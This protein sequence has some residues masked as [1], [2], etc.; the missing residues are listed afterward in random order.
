M[1]CYDYLIY[2]QNIEKSRFSR[3]N[4]RFEILKK[5]FII[6]IIIIIITLFGIMFGGNNNHKEKFL[7][8][9]E[10]LCTVEL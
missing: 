8:G 6:I 2:W 1:T 9:K 5:G 7:I 3:F 4:Q 10:N